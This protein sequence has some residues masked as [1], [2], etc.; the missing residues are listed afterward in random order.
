MI[1]L[2]NPS[3]QGVAPGLGAEVVGIGTVL[4]GTLV[5][6]KIRSCLLEDVLHVPSA[7]HGLLSPG[8]AIEQGF[9]VRQDE[10]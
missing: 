1:E 6:G 7:Q 10:D 3:I 8:R 9:N 2:S 4:P 5:N